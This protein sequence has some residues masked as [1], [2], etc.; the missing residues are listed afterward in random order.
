MPFYIKHTNSHYIHRMIN[1]YDDDDDDGEERVKKLFYVKFI[2]K[3]QII[4]VEWNQSNN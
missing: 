2:Q 4:N 3:I 1:E